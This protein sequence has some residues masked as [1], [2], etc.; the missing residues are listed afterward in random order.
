MVEIMQFRSFLRVLQVESKNL[1]GLLIVIF[2]KKD[3]AEFID[4]DEQRSSET[5]VGVF[6]VGVRIWLCNEGLVA[7]GNKGAVAISLKICES[8]VCFINS[9]LSAHQEKVKER[10]QDYNNIKNKTSFYDSRNNKMTIL[11]HE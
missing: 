10:I 4:V 2:V 6:G 1:V 7:Q 11:E 8:T 3:K 5:A 9:H